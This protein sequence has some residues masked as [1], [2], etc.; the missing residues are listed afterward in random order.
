M[1]KVRSNENHESMG[2]TASP[3]GLAGLVVILNGIKKVISINFHTV[4]KF[5]T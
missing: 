2:E 3:N 1:G 5:F 4:V